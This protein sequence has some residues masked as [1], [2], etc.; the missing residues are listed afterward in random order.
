[1]PGKSL[2]TIPSNPHQSF[3]DGNLLIKKYIYNVGHLGMCRFMIK[4]VKQV[5]LL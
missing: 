4:T 3:R 2:I 1:M 5:I